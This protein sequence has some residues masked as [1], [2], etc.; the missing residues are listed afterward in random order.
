MQT[1][2]YSIAPR[3]MFACFD[4]CFVALAHTS[5]YSVMTLADKM[6]Y[7]TS[8]DACRQL[9]IIFIVKE[10]LREILVS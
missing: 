2:Y 6:F 9:L 5:T 4:A 7:F 8:S 1:V 3:L 10:V